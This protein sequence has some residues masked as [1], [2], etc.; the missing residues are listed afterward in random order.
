MN[1][2]LWLLLATLAWIGPAH[3]APARGFGGG[4]L[5]SGG[6]SRFGGGAAA[7]GGPPPAARVP[8]AA[9]ALGQGVQ[10]G[11]FQSSSYQ[12]GIY[13]EGFRA[14]NIRSPAF[15]VSDFGV[16][17]SPGAGP[18]PMSFRGLPTDEGLH[19]VGGVIEPPSRL[20][21]A[22][23]R[24]GSPGA[25][26]GGGP[27]VG[28]ESPVRPQPPRTPEA[29]LAAAAREAFGEYSL[30]TPDWYED[31]AAAWHSAEARKAAWNAA[32]WATVNAWFEA[33]WPENYYDYG[34]MIVIA[35]DGVYY[36]GRRVAKAADYSAAAIDLAASGDAE[37]KPDEAWLTLGVFAALRPGETEIQMLFQ[38]AVSKQGVLRGTYVNLADDAVRVVR[39][40]VDRKTQRAAWYVGDQPDGVL[41]TGL[42]NLT[43][44]QAPV[45]VHFLPDHTEQWL[46][47]RLERQEPKALPE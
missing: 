37:P 38:L 45:L 30:F 39:G 28:V 36:Y 10:G 13:S 27:A 41:D 15:R 6:A 25:A 19:A 17:G 12:G 7:P 43:R 5:F 8:G 46:L 11:S 4:S 14:G 18:A 22:R 33:D 29:V 40:A 35:G 32:A 23:A 1:K 9:G 21:T 44:E 26:A 31:H 42:F 2:L 34:N 20:G 3:E 16:P 24:V 47:V